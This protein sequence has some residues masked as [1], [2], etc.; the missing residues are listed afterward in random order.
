M[1][2]IEESWLVFGDSIAAGLAS[3]LGVSRPGNGVKKDGYGISKVG[4]NPKTVLGFL[5]EWDVNKFDGKV[6][7]LS[8]G[9]T[10]ASRSMD[11]YKK[12]IKEQVQLLK[13][14]NARVVVLGVCTAYTNWKTGKDFPNSGSN[15]IKDLKIP[16]GNVVLKE[17]AQAYAQTFIDG[18]QR[19]NDGLHPAEWQA[20]WESKFEGNIP[21]PPAKK[22]EVS[23]TEEP[24]QG[25]GDN[26]ASVSTVSNDAPPPKEDA[27][28]EK[29]EVVEQP[30]KVAVANPYGVIGTITLK[31]KSGPGEIV[32]EVTKT[33]S[34]IYLNRGVEFSD[35]S[36]T[37]PGDYEIVVVSDSPNV[38]GYSFKVSVGGEPEFVE[39]PADEVEIL[40]KGVQPCI[41]QVTKPRIKIS[42]MFMPKSGDGELDAQLVTNTGIFPFM[43]VFGASIV[44]SDIQV[45][46]L[47]HD[48]IVPKCT[49]S[50]VDTMGL[51]K[52][53][54]AQDNSK[55][56]IFIDSRDPNLKSIHLKFK[57]EKFTRI[58]SSNSYSMSG[59]LHI[60][61]SDDYLYLQN[62]DSFR[63]TSMEVLKQICDKMGLGFNTNIDSTDDLMQWMFCGD[64]TYDVITKIINHSYVSEKSFMWGY[65]DYYYC[66]NYIDIEKELARSI[67]N[68]IG[69]ETG[70]GKGENKF[71]NINLFNDP[72]NNSSCFFFDTF[73]L[74]NTSTRQ[75]IN[76][77]LRTRI[78]YY[79]QN[80]K[81]MLIFDVD[82]NTS[83]PSTNHILKGETYNTSIWNVSI[84]TDFRGTIDTSNVHKNYYY[85][86]VLNKR[87]IDDLQKI[88][89]TINL[90]HINLNLY[91]GM[92]VNVDLTNMA[93]N[94]QDPSDVSFRLSGS[95]IV[96]DIVFLFESGTFHQKVILARRELGKTPEEA[97][98]EIAP[99]K[100]QSE[101]TTNPEPLILNEQYVVG[102][103]YAF[104]GEDGNLYLLVVKSKSDDGKNITAVIKRV[105]ETE[106]YYGEGDYDELDEEYIEEGAISD[107]ESMIEILQDPIVI[108]DL[109]EAEEEAKKLPPLDPNNPNPFQNAKPSGISPSEQGAGYPCVKATTD[110]V[111]KYCN[112]VYPALQHP[113][114][115]FV[116]SKGPKTF[117]S[118][119][120]THILKPNPAYIQMMKSVK[121]PMAS[122]KDQSISVH[123]ELAQKLEAVFAAVRS[124]NLRGAIK[125]CAG[126]LC[127]RNVTKGK[128]LSNHAYGFAV[129]I[130]STEKG[131]RYGDKWDTK[132]KKIY[133]WTQKNKNGQIT[134]WGSRDYTTADEMYYKMSVIMANYG[135]GWLKSMDPM[136]FSIHE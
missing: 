17:I 30:K 22:S 113:D 64:R 14:A 104:D 18:F 109:K 16:E 27:T 50:F 12:Y 77:G 70:T 83:D 60:P 43:Q 112:G 56:E 85:A 95:W 133:Y 65:I 15:K 47:Y 120:Q 21:G 33:I 67:A 94:P 130:N 107:A 11:T 123:P 69:V 125:S 28:K 89:M 76:T 75:S 55:F 32:G 87:N 72:T 3:Y 23:A 46:K 106:V 36:F 53:V 98:E 82:G 73:D 129:D 39:Q 40:V 20:W 68:D 7:F 128:R 26:N 13:D 59:T 117:T 61:E 105:V 116:I 97:R 103:T 131:Y 108:A 132:E 1:A 101:Q 86:P 115:T 114:G 71:A 78:K 84:K 111:K 126:G 41:A 9:Y 54:T 91:K 58:E 49:V 66:F 48:G 102:E 57:I 110:F 45:M 122:G 96:S 90:P 31:K 135:V 35:I 93:P 29:T 34:N 6:V 8:T 51:L 2:K 124:Q 119:K 74:K 134:A 5:K 24:V 44:H 4:A 79:D 52:T 81:Q 80:L 127:V 121:V 136:H 25:S 92:K 88:M 38:D 99:I 62:Y 100:T 63:G 10:N 118:W 19:S 42:P 37:Q